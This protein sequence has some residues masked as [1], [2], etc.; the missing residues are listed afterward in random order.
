MTEAEVKNMVL[1]HKNDCLKEVRDL[2]EKSV[3]LS[4]ENSLQIASVVQQLENGHKSFSALRGEDEKTNV[5]IDKVEEK[6]NDA[7]TSVAKL[8][9]YLAGAGVIGAGLVKLLG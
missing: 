6:V 4:H 2:I 9:G 8:V 3:A 7:R 5:R 1:E